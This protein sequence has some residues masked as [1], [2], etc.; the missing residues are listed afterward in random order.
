M[1]V[2]ALDTSLAACQCAVVS[3]GAALAVT[4]EAMVRGHQERLAGMVEETLARAGVSLG[5]VDLIAVTLGPG[6][7][8]GL[9]VGLAFAKGLSFALA[10]PLAGVG[11]LEALA[12]SVAP[13]GLQAAVIDAGR[14]RIY[15]QLFE[16]GASLG[17][18]QILDLAQ[19]VAHLRRVVGDRE[20]ALVG[21]GAGLLA[22]ALPS[23]RVAAI[24]APT[25]GAI[26]AL[27]AA[28]G[29]ATDVSPLYLRAPDATPRRP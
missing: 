20:G 3:E 7:F 4:S 23:L 25:P 2:L 9:R 12:A 5:A 10:R 24:I 1:I 16:G 28:G 21:P 13:D 26:A 29:A 17:P 11:S 19:A 22:A 6:S 15:L 27:A 14:G 8:T 18:P